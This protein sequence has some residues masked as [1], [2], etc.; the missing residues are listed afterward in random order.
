MYE[1]ASKEAPRLDKKIIPNPIQISNKHSFPLNQKNG[2]FEA[3]S[4]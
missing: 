1:S 2:L 4:V 3:L